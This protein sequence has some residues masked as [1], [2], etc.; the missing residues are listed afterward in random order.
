MPSTG[1]ALTGFGMAQD[2]EDTRAAG[3]VEHLVKPVDFRELAAVAPAAGFGQVDAGP[4]TDE[5][6]IRP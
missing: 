4:A 5:H 2:R 6:R 3:F 1:I